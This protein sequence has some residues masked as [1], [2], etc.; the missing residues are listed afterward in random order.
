MPEDAL[1]VAYRLATSGGW[2]E[3]E[4]Q[5]EEEKQ[6]Q[7]EWKEG[8]KVWAVFWEDGR[9]YRAKYDHY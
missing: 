4:Q 9:T 7:K 8:Q 1:V 3:G 6:P 2:E 5:V